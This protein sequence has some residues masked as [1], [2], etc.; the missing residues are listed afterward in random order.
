MNLN[1]VLVS[2]LIPTYNCS[3]TII[4]ALDSVKNQTYKNLEIIIIDD[5]SSDNTL[6]I[7]NEYQ[8]N[9]SFLS[10]KIITKKENFGPAHSRNI[11]IIEAKGKYIALLDSDDF[12]ENNKLEVQIG[13]LENNQQVFGTSCY[14]RCFGL[15]KNIIETELDPELMKDT[16]LIGMPYLHASFVFR[17]DFIISNNLFYNEKYR[18]AE[19]YEWSVRFFKENAI[20]HNIP[21]V[22]HNYRISGMQESFSLNE[23]GKHII[24]KN[25]WN[26]AKQIHYNIWDEFLTKDNSLYIGDNIEIFLGHKRIQNKKELDEF[27][28]WFLEIKKYNQSIKYH[29]KEKFLKKN[30]KSIIT[31]YY[32]SRDKFN[33][34]LLI[35]LFKKYHFTN[36]SNKDLI[37]F[38]GKCL[39]NFKY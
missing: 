8:S 3:N 9:N 1:D 21:V 10:I 14:L 35:D 34:N 32:L 29:F 25:Q 23:D 33:L 18:T 38:I 30:F 22:L 31:Y 20:V 12:F 28:R 2:V 11:G 13:Y 15:Q 4:K 27:V 39:V 36:F 19:D 17:R 7:V 26:V 37:K 6:D 5:F 16:L 24:N